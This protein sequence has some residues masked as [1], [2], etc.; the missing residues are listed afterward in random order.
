[1]SSKSGSNVLTMKGSK[2][3]FSVSAPAAASWPSME[4]NDRSSLKLEE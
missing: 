2:V 4:T 3:H 1:M